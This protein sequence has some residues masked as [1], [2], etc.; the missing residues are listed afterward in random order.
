MNK[1]D[2]IKRDGRKAKWGKLHDRTVQGI[3]QVLDS[4]GC[5]NPRCLFS[6]TCYRYFRQVFTIKAKLSAGVSQ[7]NLLS[8]TNEGLSENELSN[9][10]IHGSVHRESNLIIVQ[11]A[12]TY[13]IYYISVGSSTCFGC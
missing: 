1:E 3:A 4:K 12:A 9:F 13:S 10:Y 5:E 2:V 7:I 11:Q 8:D 6:V